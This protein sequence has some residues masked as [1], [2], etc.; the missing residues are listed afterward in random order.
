MRI[1]I[2]LLLAVTMWSSSCETTPPVS[3]TTGTLELVFKTRYDNQP[4]VLFQKTSTGQADPT[5]ILVKKLD[6]FISEIKGIN[7]EGNSSTFKDVGYVSMANSISPSSAEEGTTFS[8]SNIPV[9]SY[10]QL[11]LGIGLPDAMND[12]KPGDFDSS[13]PLGLNGN[14]WASWNSY[15]LSKIEGD[16]TK[17]DDSNS[18]FLYHSGV[19]GMYQPRSYTQNFDIAAD[20]TT[21]LVFYINVKDIFFKTGSELDVL[22][23]TQTHSGTVGSADY[24][25]AKKSI[26]NLANAISIQS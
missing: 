20:Q 18:G 4:F 6:F 24:N 7:Q 25:L 10:K 17:A 5:D 12:K 16:F 14:Y 15:I 21:Q 2:L 26:E 3:E 8:I 23:Q 1:I 22:N 11:D 13:S 19:N 9:G